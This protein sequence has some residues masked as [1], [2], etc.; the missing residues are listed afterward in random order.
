MYVYTVHTVDQ[1]ICVRDNLVFD[2]FNFHGL[3]KPQKNLPRKLS[4]QHIIEHIVI[5]LNIVCLV[6]AYCWD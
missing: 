5:Q 4:V 2:A 6:I 3:P 1:E